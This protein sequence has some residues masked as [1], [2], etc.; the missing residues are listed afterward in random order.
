MSTPE[1]PPA[2]DPAQTTPTPTPWKLDPA[3]PTTICHGFS[4]VGEMELTYGLQVALANAAFAVKACNA[5]ATL[6]RDLAAAKAELATEKE[7]TAIAKRECR[8]LIQ[9]MIGENPSPYLGHIKFMADELKEAIRVRTEALQHENISLS[10]ENERLKAVPISA[11]ADET[12][13]QLRADLAAKEAL[14]PIVKDYCSWL[15]RNGYTEIAE[16]HERTLSAL[17]ARTSG[18]DAKGEK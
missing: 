13:S 9:W 1:I 3:H 2:N 16:Q 4:T 6:E 15:R 12:I 11:R 10:T 18:K 17:S 8:E 7:L 5:Y 14:L